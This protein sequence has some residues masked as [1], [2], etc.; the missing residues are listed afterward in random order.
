LLPALHAVHYVGVIVSLDLRNYGRIV[1]N[2]LPK[3]GLTLL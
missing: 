2:H 1:P 3:V